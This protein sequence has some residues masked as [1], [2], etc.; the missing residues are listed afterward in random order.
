MVLWL[1]IVVC[2]FDLRYEG[3]NEDI[4]CAGLYYKA[5]GEAKRKHNSI[6]CNGETTTIVEE[7]RS[8]SEEEEANRECALQ[9]CEC[10]D[11]RIP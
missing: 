3:L 10:S 7:A 4:I 2:T 11:G 8:L 5:V 1:V 6:V 9:E